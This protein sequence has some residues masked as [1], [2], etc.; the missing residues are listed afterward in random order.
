VVHMIKMHCLYAWN[1][2]EDLDTIAERIASSL[3]HEVISLERGYQVGEEG[4]G[5]IIISGSWYDA[6]ALVITREK[7]WVKLERELRK[8]NFVH[9]FP[10]PLN[11]FPILSFLD[12]VH[13]QIKK[14][15]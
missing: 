9:R 4:F 8:Y 5:D 1:L 10:N 11:L 15:K 14:L 3:G 7:D 2:K 13:K 12:Y 6:E